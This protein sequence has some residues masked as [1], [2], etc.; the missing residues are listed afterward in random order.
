MLHGILDFNA[1]SS[2][3]HYTNGSM[4]FRPHNCSTSASD[5]SLVFSLLNY[6]IFVASA[7]LKH[8]NIP[9]IGRKTFLP[10]P[11][12]MLDICTIREIFGTVG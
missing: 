2:T 4:A 1:M 3:K 11:S 6:F 5:R 9:P 10:E 7:W 12:P 8:Y